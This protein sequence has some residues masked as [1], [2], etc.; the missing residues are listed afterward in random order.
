MLAVASWRQANGS[1]D[2]HIPGQSECIGFAR[3]PTL[4]EDPISWFD[5][6]PP[7]RDM[8]ERLLSVANPDLIADLRAVWDQKHRMILHSDCRSLRMCEGL[9]GLSECYK[10]GH[11]LEKSPVLVKFERAFTR[12]LRKACEKKSCWRPILNAGALLVSVAQPFHEALFF[13]ISFQNL[14]TWDA[15]FLWLNP[16]GEPDRLGRT[17]MRLAKADLRSSYVDK[18]RL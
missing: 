8:A 11:C 12:F 16:V 6:C 13:H 9:P 10:K 4:V 2:L 15:A 14:T 1:E 17:T 18:A 3:R 7:C 5:V